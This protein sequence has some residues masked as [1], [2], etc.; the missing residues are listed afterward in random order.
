[1]EYSTVSAE[2]QSG[3]LEFADANFSNLKMFLHFYSFN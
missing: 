3:Y 2:E 1:M